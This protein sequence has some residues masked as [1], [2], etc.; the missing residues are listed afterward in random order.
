MVLKL[1]IKKFLGDCISFLFQYL[2]K[3][4]YIRYGNIPNEW[5]RDNPN[6]SPLYHTIYTFVFT[7]LQYTFT[8]LPMIVAFIP[9]LIQGLISF[10]S[11][12]Y[13][14]KLCATIESPR[15]AFFVVNNYN[16][17]K[18]S[19]FKLCLF[20]FKGLFKYDELVFIICW[21]SNINQSVLD[22]FIYYCIL[23]LEKLLT[24]Q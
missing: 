22:E 11:D 1:R 2:L 10:V 14:Y 7:I 13:L 3:I 16:L 18:Y 21:K 24:I 17:L 23:L 4:K 12:I 19:Y 8:D 20:F 15:F 9:N 5:T 6:V